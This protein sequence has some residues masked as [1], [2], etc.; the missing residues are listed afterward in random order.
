LSCNLTQGRGRLNWQR[1]RA[2]LNLRERRS[3]S[4]K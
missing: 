4:I 2:G 3:F 1:G